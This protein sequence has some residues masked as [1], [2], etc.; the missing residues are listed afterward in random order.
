MEGREGGLHTSVD[1]GHGKAVGGEQKHHLVPPVFGV[2]GQRLFNVLRKCLDQTSVNRP[3]VDDTPLDGAV[4]AV[5]ESPC[6]AFQPLA[7]LPQLVE[8]AASRGARILGVLGERDCASSLAIAKPICQEPL[9]HLFRERVRISE[10]DVGL[11]W[12]RLGRDLIQELAHLGAL[13][14]GPFANRG[15][16]ANRRILLLNFGC[17]STRDNRSQVA[18]EAAKGDQVCV[19][20]WGWVRGTMR[21]A[22]GK[23][24]AYKKPA[25]K[26]PHLIRCRRPSHVEKDHRRRALRAEAVLGN[27]K[28]GRRQPSRLLW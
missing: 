26:V 24:V 5:V 12:R 16:A 1:H 18:L 10:G 20:L 19:R 17:P 27:G 13:M 7:P 23:G 8:T 14:F 22:S 15:S 11:V 25:Q 28:C 2:L 4:T 21:P 9:V 3:P 6:L